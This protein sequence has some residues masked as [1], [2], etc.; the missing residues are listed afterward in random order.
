[1]THGVFTYSLV[2]DPN[3][4]NDSGVKVDAA[5]ARY[6]PRT[7]KF[8]VFA[9]GTSNP[10][11]VDFD[12][13]GNA[14]VSACVIDHLFHVIPGGLYV[15]QG[16]TPANPYTY[17]M[18]PSIVDHK[19]FRAA[20]AGAQIYQGNMYPEQYRGTIMMGNIHQSAIN[21]DSL[22]RVGSSFLATTNRD[23]LVA[24][25]GWFRPVSTQ[26]GPDGALW[27]M[28][29][30]DKYPCY[31]NA[32]ADP[33]GVDREH[34]RIWRVVYTG[35]KP[36]S[37][38]PSRPSKDMNLAKAGTAELVALLKHENVWQRRVAQRLLSERRDA[39][40]KPAL[41][42]LLLEGKTLEARLGALWSLH[43]ADLLDDATL[44]RHANDKEAPVRTWVARLTGERRQ[45]N[46]ESLERLKKLAA[47]EDASVRL[48]VTVAC[49]QYSSGSL[50]V[51]TSVPED[52]ANF[53]VG[54][55]LET[56]VQ[57]STDAKDPL[58]PF[59]VWMASEPKIAENP[60]FALRWGLEHAS[61]TM[62]LSG[63]FITKIMRRICDLQSTEYMNAA[64]EFLGKLTS[65]QA[66]LAVAALDGLI[67]G[68][69]GSKLPTIETAP[70]LAKLTF[71]PQVTERAQRLGAL[72]GDTA[73]TERLLARLNDP[74]TSETDRLRVIQ[75]V[76]QLKTDAARDALI[77][78][79]KTQT[80]ESLLLETIRALGETGGDDV[81]D[82]AL[83]RWQSL[84]PAARRTAVEVLVSRNRWASALLKAIEQKKVA[85][86][87][88]SASAVRSLAQSSD[89]SIRDRATKL[90]GR[91]R[92]SDGDKLKVIAEKRR[93][94]LGGTP[95][96]QAGREVAAKT[97]F[98]CHKLHGEGADVGPD[99]TGVGRSTLDA[100][101]ANIID[102]NQIIGKGYENVEIETKDGR[103]ISGRLV[104]ETDT[105]VKLVSSGP[106]EETVARSEI[107]K[108]RVTDLSVMP[109]GLEQMPDEDFRNMV[110]YIL[111]PPQDNRP[112]TPALRK[113]LIG[114]EQKGAAIQPDGR[115]IVR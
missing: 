63:Q 51:N 113:E 112:L 13:A 45:P 9:D 54:L 70:I 105:R 92:A 59:M 99:L 65:E 91:Y 90:V 57:N 66:G 77:K 110:W 40:A 102:P 5:V 31:Q 89:T 109:E 61:E 28:D 3:D 86:T 103:V 88:I 19:H 48:G 67:Q 14:F 98:V 69:K 17:Q 80:K 93:V 41:L 62:P 32:N 82:A 97:C 36:G 43:G 8:E 79:L 23:F 50:T 10:W 42:K 47:D 106:K 111:N 16:G 27:V 15:R 12:R 30:Y 73:A 11:G 44:D 68:N 21:H 53:R 35:N 18:L 26:V 95:N 100:L 52:V 87:D 96:L 33:E 81:P 64:V 94:V 78:L 49:R 85:S 22:K 75:S 20:Y 115:A 71:T 83:N 107:G 56:V 84:S 1:M 74:G 55:I 58:I 114:E 29:W 39:A 37:K 25:D 76:G 6:H 104:E 60:T 24:N 34:G 38:V 7:K 108:M 101:L 72:W 2:K 46:E 4:P